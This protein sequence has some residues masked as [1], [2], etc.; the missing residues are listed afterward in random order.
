MREADSSAALRKDNQGCLGMTNK[1]GGEGEQTTA[2]AKAKCG[3]LSTTA[4][5][6]PPS[7]EM[8]Q[9]GWGEGEQTTA[10]AKAKCGGLSTTAAKSPPSVEMTQLGWGRVR[11]N[12]GKS[13]GEMR[14]SSTAAAKSP[15]SVEMTQLGWGARLQWTRW[16][17]AIS[18][19]ARGSPDSVQRRRLEMP[20]FFSTRR[21]KARSFSMFRSEEHTS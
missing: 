10:R 17:R 12:D 20:Q 9:L 1:G 21:V 18:F 19:S 6:S 11:T 14:G 5:K 4:A 7:V 3:G 8:T 2:R 15:P 16:R 13:K